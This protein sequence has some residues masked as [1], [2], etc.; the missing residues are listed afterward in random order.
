MQVPHLHHGAG[1]TGEHSRKG[2]EK[3]PGMNVVAVDTLVIALEVV[4]FLR[5]A[6][7]GEGHISFYLG[8][9]QSNGVNDVIAGLKKVLV[10]PSDCGNADFELPENTVV[11]KVRDAH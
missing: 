9:G 4:S 6:T 11:A 2:V 10:A 5:A 3:V 7:G 1:R 8:W